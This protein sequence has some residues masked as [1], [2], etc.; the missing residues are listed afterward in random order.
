MASKK[1]NRDPAEPM[2]RFGE[3]W[4]P[5]HQIWHKM[6]IANMAADA[7]ERFNANF[8]HLA[9]AETRDVVPLAR[10]HLTGIELHEPS[11]DTQPELAGI[12]RGLL[13]SMSPEDVTETLG[14][15]YD[16]QLDLPQLIQLV[17]E[18]AYSEALSREAHRCVLNRVSPEQT[19]TLWNEL[20]RPAPSG[21]L[22]TATKI[23]RLLVS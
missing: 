20:G 1:S 19:A 3:T 8:P 14:D 21:G 15:K 4:L 12:A 5:A 17:G 9:S 10:R 22:W 16:A 7:I 13:E 11:R 23:T 6:D 18:A 2:I